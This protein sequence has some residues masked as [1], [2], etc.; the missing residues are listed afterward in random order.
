MPYPKFFP[1]PDF[2]ALGLF[3][4]PDPYYRRLVNFCPI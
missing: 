4:R 2:M 3:R 1:H